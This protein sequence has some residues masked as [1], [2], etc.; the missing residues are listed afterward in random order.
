MISAQVLAER[1]GLQVEEIERLREV[2][3]E[4]PW[5]EA[6]Y[7]FGSKARPGGAGRDLDFA[8]LPA[9][10]HTGQQKLELLGELTAAGFD[11]VDLAF[12]DEEDFFLRFEAVRPNC[13]L[14]QSKGFDR[15]SFYSKVIR[16]YLDFQPYLKRQLEAAKR[17]LSG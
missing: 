1:C 2:F 14:Y 12:L 11:A 8:V 7:L 13:V 15:G 3:L 5:I 17:R 10:A 16:Q 6:V 9:D 4:I